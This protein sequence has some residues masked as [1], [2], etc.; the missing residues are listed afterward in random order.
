[1]LDIADKGKGALLVTKADIVEKDTKEV[2]AICT[3]SVFIRGIGGFGR[4]GTFKSSVPN[5]IP[6]RAPD[7]VG[8]ETTTPN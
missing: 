5:A 6:K 3:A 2:A 4:K 1:M 7:F 8:E